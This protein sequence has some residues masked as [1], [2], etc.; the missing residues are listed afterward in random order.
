MGEAWSTFR[1]GLRLA[2]AVVLFYAPATVLA[3]SY[4]NPGLGQQ[5]VIT[6]P[7]D[8]KPLGVRAGSFMI[9]PGVELAAEWT[10]N[11][12]YSNTD[13]LDD[14]IYHIRPYIT[15]QSTWSRHSFSVRLAADIGR[16]K[17]YGF[18][19]YEDYFLNV[20]GR[21]DI[22]TRSSI[23]YGLDYMQL[24]EGLNI[25][26]AE[27]GVEPTRYTLTGGNIGFTHF[28]NRM[29][30]GA[31]LSHRQLDYDD[32]VRAD[33]TV[34]DNQDRNR[35]DNTIYVRAD[36]LFK[37][38]RSIFLSASWRQTDFKQEL[39]RN[40]YNRNADNYNVNLGVRFNIT[41]VLDGDASVG[42]FKSEFDDPQLVGIDG[43]RFGAGLTWFPTQLTTV[44]GFIST[45]VQPTTNEFSS[46]YLSTLY[47]IRVDH[48]LLR[49]LQLNA[50]LSFR[51]ND[52]QLLEGAPEN[53][54]SYDEIWIAGIGATY[55]FNRYIRLSA[56]YDYTKMDTNVPNDGFKVNRIWLVLGFEY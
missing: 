8:F 25:R 52:Y 22:K 54:R 20:A 46:G 10:D 19:D 35:D 3:Q 14:T 30:I 33:G 51:D 11:V 50:R 1:H 23:D 7:Q 13:T 37:T 18:R 41:G 42:Y 2:A 6:H 39:D 49:D 17:D 29:S 9:H 43:W 28:F 34:I 12:F 21:F 16:H 45:S 32:G 26:S 38:D 4:D 27:Q 36:Y 48:E 40:G 15:A 24:H 31:D 53:A 44:R 56:S 5:P 55:F 47:G